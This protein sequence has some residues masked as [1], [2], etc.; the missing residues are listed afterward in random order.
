MLTTVN[1]ALQRVPPRETLA[2]QS[3]AAA[4]GNILPMAGVT[5]WLALNG[6]T[7]AAQCPNPASS[8]SAA[9][10]SICSRR[11]DEPVRLDLFGD[12][13]ETIRAFDRRPSARPAAAGARSVAG[14]EA[15]LDT[16]TIR[17]FRNGYVAA[18]GAAGRRSALR[19]GQR[20][21][22]RRRHGALAAAV[23]RAPRYG[24]RLSA[25]ASPVAL[26]PLAAEPATSAWR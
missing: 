26:E 9:G 24:V 1:A 16:D 20:G 23:L 7:R 6:F 15:L 19:R 10:S 22:P 21:P 18:F 4:P 11:A 13:L 14:G 8:R 25:E 3:L 17:A 2:R 5:Q 12:T